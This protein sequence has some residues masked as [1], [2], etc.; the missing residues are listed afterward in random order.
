MEK[1]RELRQD[2]VKANPLLHDLLER[3][4]AGSEPV[5]TYE[6][7][8]L[9]LQPVEDITHTFSPEELE[10]FKR[11]Y[12]SAEDTGNRYT[13]EQAMARFRGRSTRDA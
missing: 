5:I 10:R 7:M 11:S 1:A 9:V 12:A 6:G 2:E 4:R 8:T 13:A 3:A